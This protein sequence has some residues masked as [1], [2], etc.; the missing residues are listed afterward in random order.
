MTLKVA[1]QTISK[2][3][4]TLLNTEGAKLAAMIGAH[5]PAS[6]DSIVN[7]IQMIAAANGENPNGQAANRIFQFTEDLIHANLM[8][9]LAAACDNSRIP[10]EANEAV[11][12]PAQIVSNSKKFLSQKATSIVHY[13]RP[14]ENNAELLKRNERL[15]KTR[16]TCRPRI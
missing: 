9:V 5:L 14:S 15:T 12:S 1:V 10:Q 7:A 8:Q 3:I 11:S 6:K 13:L 4:K 2:R 16:R